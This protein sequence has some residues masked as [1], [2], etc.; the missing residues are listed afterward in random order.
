MSATDREERAFLEKLEAEA[1]E[2]AGLKELED[3]YRQRHREVWEPFNRE[4]QR[5]EH[6]GCVDTSRPEFRDRVARE[7]GVTTRSRELQAL[8][9]RAV[10]EFVGRAAEELLKSDSEASRDVLEKFDAAWRELANR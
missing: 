2:L 7:L 8:Y 3:W 5:L 10:G 4:M 9:Q 6:E 1:A